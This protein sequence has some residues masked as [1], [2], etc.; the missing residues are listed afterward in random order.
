MIR[1]FRHCFEVFSSLGIFRRAQSTP[2]EMAV[3]VLGFGGAKARLCDDF[4][5]EVAGWWED[6]EE[7]TDGE[8]EVEGEAVEAVRDFGVFF[9]SEVGTVEGGEEAGGAMGEGDVG[10]CGGGGGEDA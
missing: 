2:I 7:G 4:L 9:D 5:E 10:G 3:L 6:E 1:E 8:K